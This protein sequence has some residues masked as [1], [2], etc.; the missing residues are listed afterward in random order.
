MHLSDDQTVCPACGIATDNNPFCKVC[1]EPL[2]PGAAFCSACGAST[3]EPHNCKICGHFLKPENVFCPGCGVK[4]G[5]N[6]PSANVSGLQTRDI[7]LAI[8]LSLV[9]CGIYSIYW[10][11]CLTNEINQA[12]GKNDDTSGGIAF[13]LSLLTCNIYGY[14]WAY[15]LGQKRDAIAGKNDSSDIIYLLLSVFGLGIVVHIL[16]QDTLNKTIEA[17]RY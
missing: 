12:S 11:I 6:K 13:L 2:K 15:K 5:E 14:Y 16:A 4:V 1:K 7:V 10:F 9:T 3:K 17:N 8:V